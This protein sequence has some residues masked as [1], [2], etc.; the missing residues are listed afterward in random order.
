MTSPNQQTLDQS[1]PDTL[2]LKRSFRTPL[3]VSLTKIGLRGACG[4]SLIVGLPVL[5]GVLLAAAELFNLYQDV[6]ARI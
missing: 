3:W 5:A 4:V 1:I 6:Y 2:T